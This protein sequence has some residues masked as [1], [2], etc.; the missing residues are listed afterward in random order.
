MA[1]QPTIDWMQLQDRF[2]RKQEIY[3]ML[4]KHMDLSKFMIAGAP[5]GGPIAMIRDDKKVLVLQKQQPV[6]PTIYLYTSAGK[7][8]EQLQWDKGRIITMGWTETEQLIV[9]L[10]DGTIRLYD[11]HGEYAQFSLGKEAKDHSVIDCQIWGTGLVVLTGNFKL[12]ALTNFEEPRPRLMADPGLNEPPHSWT[13]IPP[14]YTLSRHVE[15][16]LATGSTILTVDAKESQDQ[17]LQQGPFTK[18]AVSPNGKF[19]ALFTTDSKL[20]VVSTDFQKNLSEYSTKFKSPPQ[21]LVWCGTDSVVMYWDKVVLMVGPSGDGIKHTYDDAIYLN[22]EVDGV[23]VISSDKCEFLQK[24]PNVTEDIYKFGSTAPGAMLVDALEHFEKRSP[25]AD[26][27]IRSIRT[28]LADAVD[29]CIEAAGHEFNQYWQ[30]N[31][32]KAASFGKAFLENYNAD[33]FVN[34]C[35]TLRVLNAVRFYEIGIPITYTQYIRL[36]PDA[37]I[38][39]LINRHNH[40]LA[41]RICEYLKMRTDRVLI[42]WACAKIKKSKDDEETICRMIVEKLANKPGLSYAEI[43]RTAHKVGQPKLATR[44]LDYEPRAADQVPLLMSM[45]EDELALTKAIDS[46]D[47][48]LVYLVMLHLKKKLLPSGEFFRIINDKPMACNLL[49]VFCKQQDLKLLKDFY[50]QD[51]RHVDRANITVLE[52]Y[53]QTD[54]HDRIDK[55]KVA[56]KAYQDDKDHSFEAKAIEENIKLLQKQSQL[57]KEIVGQQ[58]VGLSVSETVHKCIMSKEPGKAD[59]LKSDFKIPDKR[60][61]WIKLKALVEM[62]E[63]AELDKLAKSKK[64]PIG[65]E[66]FVEECIKAMQNREAA[67]YILKCEPAVRP[68]LFI[69]MGDFKAAGQEALALKDIQLLREIR[70]KCTNHIIAQELDAYIAQLQNRLVFFGPLAKRDIWK[71]LE[72]GE[73]YHF[74]AFEYMILSFIHFHRLLL[75][76]LSKVKMAQVALGSSNRQRL[77][78]YLLLSK[79]AKGAASVQL[80]REALAAPGI[81]V[82]AELLEMPNVAELGNHEQ[83]NPYHRLLRLFSYGTYKDYKENSEIL[84]KLDQAQLNK[85]KHLSIVSLSE[86]TRTIPY[87]VL[88]S[89]L[90]ISNVRELED[91]IIEAIYQDVIKGKLDQKKKQ[92]EIECTMGR[93]LR[94]GQ[95]D[96]MLEVLKAWSQTSQ[97]ILKTIDVKIQ[98]VREAAAANKLDKEKYEADVEK[99]RKNVKISKN[100]GHDHGGIEQIDMIGSG[101]EPFQSVEYADENSRSSRVGKRGPKRFLPGRR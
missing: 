97:E 96:H 10:E 88:L 49:E 99:A 47:T 9:V 53:E 87:D 86:E 50:Y 41:L 92:L 48:D 40:L 71:I 66:P 94:P 22:P 1:P 24:V 83:H 72:G 77:E 65:Y 39:R 42:H 57:E 29:A 43:A 52:S 78:P 20:W 33:H 89:Y 6:K 80:I 61:W 70:S 15:V 37:L 68:G 35:Q 4:W 100:S 28:E 91:L 55:L 21:Q 60:F 79:S 34:I 13:V 73:V 19:L 82:F 14:Q 36:T 18:M 44:L 75:A 30:R 67:K 98:H 45:Q 11:I 17:L 27:N 63:W 95:I 12:V 2:Y 84:P 46:G 26:D 5:N 54:L 101:M 59:K 8:M 64:S 58:F 23:R 81:Y 90:D 51:D 7:L 32:L 85:L 62:R 38:D 3:T 93:D 74:Q 76:S 25:K 69:K 31:L 16:L 56:L